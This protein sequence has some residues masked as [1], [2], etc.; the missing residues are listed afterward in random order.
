MNNILN[1]F[2]IGWLPL[3]NRKANGPRN[4]EKE[5]KKQQIQNSRRMPRWPPTNMGQLQT[6]Q[7]RRMLDPWPSTRTRT[8]DV[9]RIKQN[10]A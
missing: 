5:P 7:L 10:V 2:E 9:I 3:N 4:S 1:R 6:I 8:N